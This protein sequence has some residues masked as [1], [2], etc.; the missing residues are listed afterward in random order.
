MKLDANTVLDCHMIWLQVGFARI[1]INVSFE[2]IWLKVSVQKILRQA[3]F[4]RISL[5]L[6]IEEFWQLMKESLCLGTNECLQSFAKSCVSNDDLLGCL[7]TRTI[8]RAMV[9]EHAVSQRKIN[10]ELVS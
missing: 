4:A 2:R 1:W 6:N 3:V 10:F 9:Y 5:L 7:F 8:D